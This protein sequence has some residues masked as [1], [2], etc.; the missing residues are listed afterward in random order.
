MDDI[1]RKVNPILGVVDPAAEQEVLARL[2]ALNF[3]MTSPGR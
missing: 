2:V 3:S 1:R